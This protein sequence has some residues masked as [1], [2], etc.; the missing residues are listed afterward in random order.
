MID[1]IKDNRKLYREC[2]KEIIDLFSYITPS[3]YK[4]LYLLNANLSNGVLK[5]TFTSIYNNTSDD[6]SVKE[7]TIDK[8]REPNNVNESEY[9]HSFKEINEK[10]IF[11]NFYL[12]EACLFHDH[13][14][15]VFCL[16]G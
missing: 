9:S 7:V 3:K 5:D 1:F 8:N 6:S 11:N 16:R 10:D 15:G 12:C 13:C 2:E 14:D 4:A